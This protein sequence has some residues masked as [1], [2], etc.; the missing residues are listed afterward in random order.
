MSSCIFNIKFN[1]TYI[2]HNFEAIN[3]IVKSNNTT[4]IPDAMT[5]VK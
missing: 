1:S 4:K 3:I 5:A 2:V